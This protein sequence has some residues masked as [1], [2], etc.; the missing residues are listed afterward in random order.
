MN[1]KKTS[2]FD[3]VEK[4]PFG[5]LN[6]RGKLTLG[7]MF[8]V[9]IVILV[10]GLFLYFRTQIAS[11]QLNTQLEENIR[12]RA[13][14]TLLSTSHE[15]ANLLNGF[16]TAMSKNTSTI[17]SSI[18]ETF[19]RKGK[20]GDGA[21]WD[22]SEKLTRLESGSW[23]NPQNEA[24]SIFVP[25]AIEMD[26][27]LS[28]KINTLKYTELFLPSVLADN[29]DIIAIYFGGVT[30]ETIYYPN[31]DLAAI[32]PPDFD[33]TGRPWFV[34]AA[35]ENNPTRAVV[36]STP[37]QDAALN[38]LVIT[39]S[40]PVMDAQDRF[41]GVAAMDIQLKQITDIVAN[42][43][44]GDTGYAFLVDSNR[45][46]IAMPEA[47]FGDFNLTDEAAKVG[48]VLDSDA[49][50]NA[51]PQFFEILTSAESNNQG[52]FSVILGGKERLVAFQQVPE[53]N[54]K[55]VI[56]VPAEELLADANL[57]REEITSGTRT[58][59]SISLILIIVIFILATVVSLSIGNR[60]TN[61]LQ[62]LT[63]VAKEI[64]AGNLEA[65][66]NIDT[67]DEIGTLAETLNTMTLSLRRA[68]YSLEQRVD[69]R[70]FA[71]QGEVK[72]GERRGQQY[73]A[74][75]KVSQAITTTQNLSELLPQ[76]SEVISHQFGFYH[77][78]IFLTDA[79]KQY[80]VLAA[81]NSE[82]GKKMLKRGHQLRVGQQGIVGYVTDKGQPRIALNVGGDAVYFN[83]PD[84][85]MTR[86]EMAL[87]LIISGEVIGALDVQSTEPNAFADD[88]VE[89]LTM[90]ADQ[91]SIAIQNARLFEQ[92]QR[93]LSEA[94]AVS[95]RYFKETWSQVA[96]EQNVAGFRYSPAGIVP[97]KDDPAMGEGIP[98]SNEPG[99]RRQVTVPIVIRGQTMG[100]LSVM[101]PRQENIR[102]DHMNLI[103][104]VA[105]RVALFAENA[106]LFE[107]TSKRAERE[108]LVSD[109]TT[110]IRG[111]NDPTEMIE[112]AIRE[113]R[114]ALNVSRIEI[115]PQKI[116]PPDK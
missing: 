91:V 26:D 25:A 85:P 30:R 38:G 84:L 94:E 111:T 64:T 56:I 78:G 87:P 69:E 44:V 81:A 53:V 2:L 49:L 33:V 101:V 39:S 77:A 108:R 80:A 11:N 34:N 113:L 67:R 22:A 54:Y 28:A 86:S 57:V 27:L 7:N 55:L 74:V 66:A 106:R 97:L 100:E 107:Q 103:H 24:A 98:T 5:R 89:V 48:E 76:I 92:I 8:I 46:M 21:F 104:A 105:D 63:Q 61:P 71:L 82:G 41:Q 73:E 51:L 14:E 29:P 58:T 16:F 3:L 60:L 93:S 115:I 13:E 116:T 102:S 19:S 47:G 35:P 112:T 68:I 37:Y 45:R 114:T 79:S 32:V 20:F 4:T 90:L 72:K 52:V 88:D 59:L 99:D 40:I 15:Q 6:L 83:N 110:K 70:T 95:R 23:D 42:I 109:I 9:F 75:A 62:D 17:G 96:Q 43:K 10:M 36:W 1:N 50:P 18:K 31:I 65:S 12:N